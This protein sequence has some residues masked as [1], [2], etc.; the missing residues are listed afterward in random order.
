MLTERA[1]ILLK[2]LVERYIA[3]GQP[4]G[5]L[6]LSHY[7]SMDLSSAS[8]RNVMADLE[9]MGLVASPHHSAGR[10]PT[11]QGFRF[12]VDRLLTIQALESKEIERLEAQLAEAEPH[13]AINQASHLLSQLT[14]FAGVVMIPKRR[15]ATVFQQLEFLRL[16]DCRVLLVVITTDGEVQNKILHT[17]RTFSANELNQ[18]AQMLNQYYAGMTLSEVSQRMLHELQLLHTDIDQ[19]MQQA[20]TASAA[21]LKRTD[22]SWVLSGEH[23]LLSADAFS[24]I[25]QLRRLFDLFEQKTALIQLLDLSLH[26]EGVQI[27]IGSESENT[28]P[29]D[30]SVVTAPYRVNG[31]IVGTLG[32]IGPTRMPYHRVIPVVDVTA[33]LLSNV[34]SVH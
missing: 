9:E 17:H 31:E 8:I 12:F 20:L 4:I 27:F 25:G 30:C 2:T 6:A 10:V 32:V 29:T 34:L 5:S 18:A 28:P 11:V 14:R 26:A 16:A 19:L 23:N 33:K 1:Q 15:N 21:V 24:N 7:A 3:D 22:E 13:A